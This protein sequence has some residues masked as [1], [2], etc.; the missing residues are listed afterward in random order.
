MSVRGTASLK[1]VEEDAG[2]LQSKNPNLHIY[3]HKG[4]D[5]DAAIVYE[6]LKP[7]LLTDHVLF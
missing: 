4:F 2:Y 3:V 7:R 1:N 5:S 6:A